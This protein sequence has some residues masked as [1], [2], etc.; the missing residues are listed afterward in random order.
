MPGN[1]NGNGKGKGTALK[2][3]QEKP[4]VS[5]RAATVP[6]NP[7]PQV[8]SKTALPGNKKNIIFPATIP[9]PEMSLSAVAPEMSFPG[10]AQKGK[11]TV[12]TIAESSTVEML[13]EAKVKP[14]KKTGSTFSAA[15]LSSSS[16]SG[17]KESPLSMKRG[18]DVEVV[19]EIKGQKTK[20]G[21]TLL[22]EK[23]K[24]SMAGTETASDTRRIELFTAENPDANFVMEILGVDTFNKNFGTPNKVVYLELIAVLIIINKK[25]YPN[26][27]ISD[28]RGQTVV[29]PKGGEYQVYYNGN[30]ICRAGPNEGKESDSLL[31]FTSG[32]TEVAGEE[33]AEG[34]GWWE[35][36]GNRGNKN[37]LEDIMSIFQKVCFE[38]A[39]NGSP[40]LKAMY[41]LLI[42]SIRSLKFN[43]DPAQLSDAIKTT[44]TQYMQW[45]AMS[46][47]QIP[48]D[49]LFDVFNN[50][51]SN[52]VNTSDKSAAAEMAVICKEYPLNC[53]ILVPS[54]GAEGAKNPQTII[55]D[56]TAIGALAY[57]LHMI[58]DSS[59]DPREILEYFP[60]GKIKEYMSNLIARVIWE[61]EYYINGLDEVFQENP[62]E[63]YNM[64]RGRYNSSSRQDTSIYLTEEFQNLSR[65][66]SNLIR[67]FKEPFIEKKAASATSDTASATSTSSTASATSTSA[68]ASDSADDMKGI[69][70]ADEISDS[71]ST[72]PSV[73]GSSAI[74]SSSLAVSG[75]AGNTNDEDDND[76]GWETESDEDDQN[77]DMSLPPVVLNW[78]YTDDDTYFKRKY[79]GKK[80]ELIIELAAMLSRERA[81]VE[82]SAWC[83]NLAGDLQRGLFPITDL[84]DG[85]WETINQNV[86]KSTFINASRENQ[87]C[88]DHSGLSYRMPIIDQ[89][90]VSIDNKHKMPLKAAIIE[91]GVS[92]V[93]NITTNINTGKLE[94]TNQEEEVDME[95]PKPESSR[96]SRSAQPSN[97]SIFESNY[98]ILKSL[99]EDEDLYIIE[100]LTLAEACTIAQ[101][102]GYFDINFDSANN[103][104]TSRDQR[105]AAFLP[106]DIFSSLFTKKPINATIDYT[107]TPVISGLSDEIAK[108]Y[109]TV[110]DF[111]KS[112]T[113]ILNALSVAADYIRLQSKN[114]ANDAGICERIT[115]SGNYDSAAPYGLVP[116]IVWDKDGKLAPF[117]MNVMLEYNL[118]ENNPPL[119]VNYVCSTMSNLKRDDFYFGRY[120]IKYYTPVEDIY[121]AVKIEDPRNY[122]RIKTELN[123]RDN[124]NSIAFYELLAAILNYKYDNYNKLAKGSKLNT[125]SR[126]PEI[127]QSLKIQFNKDD[128]AS[129]CKGARIFKAS[130]KGPPLDDKI[131]TLLDSV[132][133]VK[134]PAK[135]VSEPFIMKLF[136]LIIVN[137]TKPFLDINQQTASLSLFSKCVTEVM[138]DGNKKAQANSLF[139]ESMEKPS[140]SSS[141]ASTRKDRSNLDSAIL[142]RKNRT[143]KLKQKQPI[144][145]GLQT[146]RTYDIDSTRKLQRSFSAQAA[147]LKTTLEKKNAN[148][149]KNRFGQI[150]KQF[151]DANSI[152]NSISNSNSNSD[153]ISPE[154]KKRQVVDYLVKKT[155]KDKNSMVKFYDDLKRENMSHRY[156]FDKEPVS[157]LIKLFDEKIQE[158]SNEDP[159]KDLMNTSFSKIK[160]RG[161]I[162]RIDEEFDDD[163]DE[164]NFD[165]TFTGNSG[166]NSKSDASTA[167]TVK[168]SPPPSSNSLSYNDDGDDTQLMDE[169]GSKRS[170]KRRIQKHKSK[171][172]GKNSKIRKTR[173]VRRVRK[174]QRSK[175]KKHSLKRKVQKYKSKK[176]RILRKNRRNTRRK[177]RRNT[178]R[179]TRRT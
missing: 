21:D 68:T 174:V 57:F 155:G 161:K 94:S 72:E 33:A 61:C 113:S 52:C 75:E 127:L 103:F 117:V 90:L 43:S 87:R 133:T 66:T 49:T 137:I 25:Y 114:L 37:F 84:T 85:D 40:E 17:E 105:P 79:K 39:D 97:K 173:K 160:P 3:N 6:K 157:D 128:F 81:R 22:R 159:L 109:R 74:L 101:N 67:I 106:V 125:I 20:K 169:G 142:S 38:I 107:M 104:I 108:Q 126:S 165:E 11:K 146:L 45:K 78:Q 99:V 92:I 65:F 121:N 95:I 8:V 139:A 166:Y 14:K 88:H 55:V 42:V 10:K 27:G 93:K 50:E 100:T 153:S 18:R 111:R 12:S 112:N 122:E 162:T 124:K 26:E 116:V 170:R 171:K 47:E 172:S 4:N 177:N 77:M 152:S 158:E 179:N 154:Q 76:E 140:S 30:I 134:E 28:N 69:D 53:P 56:K 9:Q 110:E 19:T 98:D 51:P 167:S 168:Y 46:T 130:Y 120:E 1:G 143:R 32:Q 73:L 63:Y 123:N 115:C 62:E 35:E 16:S 48:T 82:S 54:K 118:G 135:L 131:K 149:L 144:A 64:L 141:S 156:N 58:I 91:S 83:M 29:L 136:A 24:E 41:Y 80:F 178:R 145:A 96:T 175:P 5:K 36:S 147:P 13:D 148:V 138:L 129:M 89:V 71:Y 163:S 60:E 7:P 132:P 23:L 15:A 176:R 164:D 34:R 150:S 2:K 44:Q 102:L 59:S 70:D 86:A 151:S 119:R 31:A